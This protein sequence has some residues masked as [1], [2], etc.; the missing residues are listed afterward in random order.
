MNRQ[1]EMAIET[2]GLT[3]YYGKARGIVDV[4]LAISQGDIFGF[5]GPNGAGKST[6]IRTLLG[7]ISASSGTARVLGLDSVRDKAT[8]LS[9]VGYIPSESQ[10]YQGMKV[11]DVLRFSASLRKKDCTK[12]ASVL[13]DRLN[14]DT[15]R[16]VEDLSLGNR[17]KVSIVCALQHDPKLY[18]L[19]E[20]T[21][22]LD[23][24]IQREFFSLLMECHVYGATIMLSSHVLSEVQRYCKH[25]AIIRE[26]SIIA[27]NTV[28]KLSST[29]ARRVRIQGAITLPL[30]EGVKDV[31]VHEN[32]IDFL[33][34]GDMQVL[35]HALDGLN[36]TDLTIEEPD[37]EEIFMHFYTQ[38]S[39][40]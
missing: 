36:F 10:F 18:L 13:C 30:A 33:Y 9:Q 28:D 24:L 40:T 32:G 8:I 7:L 29:A 6:F 3:K 15:N 25:A 22:G 12:R 26:G 19:D 16:K 1:N 35:I 5:I 31:I 14:L 17:K 38:G 37:I 4:D 11:K 21:S 27:A 39:V 20:P 34:R 23:P 2:Q